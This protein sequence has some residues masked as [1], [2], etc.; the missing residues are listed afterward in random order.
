MSDKAVQIKEILG[1]MSE[2]GHTLPI[3]CEIVS[4]QGDSCTVKIEGGLEL[5][6]VRLRASIGS[7]SD[8]LLITP[9]AGSKALVW[10]VTGTLDD[11]VLVKVDQI[12]KITYKQDGLELEID[13]MSKKVS[14]KNNQVSMLDLFDSIFDIITNIKVNTPSG[15][16]VGILP[17][18]VQALAQFKQDYNNILS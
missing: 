9:K 16:S 5:S 14:V 3:T 1:K 12:E 15:P 7:Q 13:S 10:S 6:D 2:K 8:E 4:V 18:T 11:L 17:D